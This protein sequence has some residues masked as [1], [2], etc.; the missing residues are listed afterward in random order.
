MLTVKFNT[1]TQ[2][3]MPFRR[4][5]DLNTED[6][7]GP[8]FRSFTHFERVAQLVEHV[9]ETFSAFLPVPGRRIRI[10]VAK[11][12]VAGSNPAPFTNR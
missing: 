12:S 7:N 1:N 3:I 5:K 9:L 8:I 6:N 2:V 11:H 10:I 4:H